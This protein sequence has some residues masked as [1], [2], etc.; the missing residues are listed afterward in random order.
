MEQV[1]LAYHVWLDSNGK[2]FGE[3]PLRLLKLVEKTG[4]LNRAAKEMG[5]SYRKAWYTIRFVE[6]RLG[7]PL[8]E[9]HSG[10]HSGGG[11]TITPQGAHFIQRYEAFRADV[12]ETLD[13]VF[14][15][16]DV[17]FNR[18]CDVSFSRESAAR[19]QKRTSSWYRK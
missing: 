11:S 16:Y 13:A 6:E 19:Q 12:K 14:K 4:S 7:F 10:G 18:N 17:P 15:K 5:M 3:G 9:R 2:A 1:K 8:L